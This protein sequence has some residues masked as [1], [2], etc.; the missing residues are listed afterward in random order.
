M[1]DLLLTKLGFNFVNKRYNM[2]N[3]NPKLSVNDVMKKFFILFGLTH[4]RDEIPII[5]KWNNKSPNITNSEYV[6]IDYDYHAREWCVIYYNDYQVKSCTVNDISSS[7]S[8][9]TF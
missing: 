1:F 6:T 7:Y 2:S 9:A 5:C 3:S 4:R 8:I